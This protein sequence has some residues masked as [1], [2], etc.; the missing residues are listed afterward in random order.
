MAT[1]GSEKRDM[2]VVVAVCGGGEDW[3]GIRERRALETRATGVWQRVECQH[4]LWGREW[5]MG[6]CFHRASRRV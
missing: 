1:M 6:A 4:N 2:V 3:T 5:L